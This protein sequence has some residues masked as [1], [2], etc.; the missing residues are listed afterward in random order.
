MRRNQR[1][2]QMSNT[3]QQQSKTAMILGEVA[4]EGL[5]RGRALLCDCAK[6][7]VVPR[8]QIAE[9]DIL[10]ELA[11][12]D[13][14][15]TAVEQTLHEVQSSVTKALGKKEADIFEAQILMLRDAE[16]RLAVREVCTSQKINVEAAIEQ[17]IQ[18][19]VGVFEKF[20]DPYLRERAAD[21]HEVR[22]RLMDHF[23]Q[24]SPPVIPS[25]PQGC[26]LV[27]SELFSFAVAQLEGRGVRGLIVEQGGLTAHATILARAMGIPM[28]VRVPHATGRI[29]AGDLVIIDALAGRAFI[30]PGSNILAAYDRLEMDLQAHQ[31]ALQHLVDQPA[32]T[33]DG[34]TVNL[35][36]HVGQTGDAV[37]AERVKANG[38]GLYRTEFA[39]FAQDHF[40]SEDEQYRFYR[41][42]AEHLWPATTVIR[43]LDIGSDKPLA[44]FPLPS[45]PNPV[46]GRRGIRLL[47]THRDILRTQLRAILRL[48]ATHPVSLLLPMICGLEEVRAVKAVVEA[49]KSELAREGQSFNSSIPV[50]A[51]IET[52]A[53]EILVSQLI[54]EVDFLSVGSNDLVQYIL[55]ADRLG[56]DLDSSYEPL[57][58]AVVRTLAALA[59][60]ARTKG[61]AISVCGEIASDPAFTA[62]LLGLGFR[63]L[64]VT[65][66]RLLE[67][68]H[69]IRSME[70]TAAEALATQVLA[71][72]TTA[73]I[74]ALVQAEWN[75][76]R[77]VVSPEL[78]SATLLEVTHNKSSQ[79]FEMHNDHETVAYLSYCSENGNTVFEHTFVSQGFR[80]K[81]IA[82][83]LVR[84]A[85]TEAR[86]LKWRI[87]PR[88]SY[89][90]GF[91]HRNP[92]LLELVVP[93]EGA[94]PT[95]KIKLVSPSH[96]QP[97]EKIKQ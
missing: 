5:A 68:K 87:V 7:A 15:V 58:P 22:K 39:F 19:L 70:L 69:T 62:L 74:R 36:A 20:D 28:L 84:A 8:R 63:N 81:G 32:V 6:Q 93:S 89:V 24:Q 41:A 66:G 4:S 65:P 60:A 26:V 97:S 42:T 79:R 83:Q 45:E 92:E 44:Y 80:G 10:A 46:L 14:A 3:E 78:C 25:D 95:A 90:A 51:M 37:A 17:A 40:P 59:N 85:L 30:N 9:S 21:L 47:L 96:L 86:H 73:E 76:R 50:G 64:S 67:I 56:G 27:T 91:I 55:A 71:L 72:S 33:R 57:H 1:V 31:S 77:P 13:E 23:A 35:S 43:V 82:A 53:A 88:C 48:S 52:P 16:L 34:V 38:A 11:R 54:D 94:P 12:F 29:A 49:V 61:K 18:R 2:K 75:Q